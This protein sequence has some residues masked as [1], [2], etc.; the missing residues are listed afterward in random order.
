MKEE[1]TGKKSKVFFKILK[2]LCL[3]VIIGLIVRRVITPT[4]DSKYP[5]E[6]AF[7]QIQLKAGSQ[8]QIKRKSVQGFLASS[9][10]YEDY[11]VYKHKYIGMF[12]P[13]GTNT[14]LI[15]G[16]ERSWLYS[17]DAIKDNMVIGE[18][19]DYLYNSYD[20]KNSTFSKSTY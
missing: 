1:T 8:V 14:E 6:A 20:I 16:G 7:N 19:E 17:A 4:W 2:I 11:I 15:S 3:V 5:T 18:N 10:S 12:S 13:N 9:F